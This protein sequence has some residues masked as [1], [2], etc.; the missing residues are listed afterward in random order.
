MEIM[1]E[2]EI[3]LYVILDIYTRNDP[4]QIG[5]TFENSS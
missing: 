5:A 1:N 3:F 4:A 2:E